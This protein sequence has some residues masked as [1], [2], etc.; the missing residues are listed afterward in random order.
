MEKKVTMSPNETALLAALWD[1]ETASPIT[2]AAIIRLFEQHGYP[3]RLTTADNTHVVRAFHDVKKAALA[4][5]EPI[6]ELSVI[7]LSDGGAVALSDG[8]CWLRA[9]PCATADLGAGAPRGCAAPRE[10]QSRLAL[11]GA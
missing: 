3:L 8:R 10:A 7:S 4:A 9:A 11:H 6:L 1:I 5:F 2:R